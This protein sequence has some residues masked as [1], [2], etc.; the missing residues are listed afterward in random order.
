MPRNQQRSQLSEAYCTTLRNGGE[1]TTKPTE[2]ERIFGVSAA[3]PIISSACL[4]TPASAARA[5]WSTSPRSCL[6][7]LSS[8]FTT[9]RSGGVCCR[10]W[11]ILS[12]DLTETA[13]LGG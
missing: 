7:F 5:C 4:L 11:F 9:S 10:F 6:V 8:S 3:G 1:V 13:W 12:C 2:L